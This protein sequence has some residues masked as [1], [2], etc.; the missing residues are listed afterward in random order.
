[1]LLVV[2]VL[3]AGCNRTSRKVYD[4]T[5]GEQQTSGVGKSIYST[6]TV[7]VDAVYE[8]KEPQTA[9]APKPE[10]K[11]KPEPAKPAK[12]TPAPAAPKPLAAKPAPTTAPVAASPTTKPATAPKTKTAA[13]PVTAAKKI[14]AKPV[15]KKTVTPESTVAAATAVEPPAPVKAPSAAAPTDADKTKKKTIDAATAKNIE[16]A[17]KQIQKKVGPITPEMLQKIQQLV[18]EGK[19]QQADMAK[20]AAIKLKVTSGKAL[21]KQDLQYL[22]ALKKKYKL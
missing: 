19:I 4:E 15:A 14:A 17:K 18:V 7:D 8:I 21:N 3:A 13:K 1:M 5:P 9:V 10:V 20:V 22:D 16:K 6:E 11:P 2:C 12:K